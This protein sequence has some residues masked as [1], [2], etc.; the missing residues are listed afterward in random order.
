VLIAILPVVTLVL[1]Y[2]PP[3]LIDPLS[4][5]LDALNE[6]APPLP[7]PLKVEYP[8]IAFSVPVLEVNIFPDA[9]NEIEPAGPIPV[10]LLLSEAF[11]VIGELM[12]IV[13]NAVNTTL[14]DARLLVLKTVDAAKLIALDTLISPEASTVNV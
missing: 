13:P 3:L 9:V 10:V 6:I 1:E 2:T 5:I 4:D 12:L 8:P 11:V 14:I 7:S